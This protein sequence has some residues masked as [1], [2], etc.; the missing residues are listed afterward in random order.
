MHPLTFSLTRY[1]TAGVRA[2]VGRRRRRAVPLV[3]ATGA[4]LGLLVAAAPAALAGGGGVPPVACDSSVPFLSGTGGY[5]TF[6][7]PSAVVL[8]S[9]AL[10]AFAEG[11]VSGAGDTG[12][13][14]V[15]ARRSEDG[16]CS[17]GPL[18]VVAEG[19]GDT[20]G[21]PAPVVDPATGRLVL[22]TCYNS[23]E[24]GEGQIMRGEVTP[25][26][27]RR[28]FVQTSDDEGRTFTAPREIT[29]QAKLPDWRWYATGPGHAIALTTGEHAGRLL[30]PANH[31]TA[32][33]AGSPD[34]GQEARYYGSHALYSDDG[35]VSWE[36]GYIDDS[37]DGLVNSNES[38]VAELPD[39]RLYFSVR[40]Q[41]GEAAGN[42]L[43]GYSSDG[44][45]SLEGPLTAQPGLESVPV[46]QGSVLR[47]PGEEG[48]L[49]FS[50][51]SNPGVREAL[52]VW[53][54]DD[55]GASFEP[56]VTLSEQPAAYSDLVRLDDGTV[57]V[58]YE[59]GVQGPY[60]TV[61]FRRLDES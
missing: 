42:R 47:L 57:G 27:S 53:R 24:V 51:P 43:G 32:P 44:G 39:G 23:G 30:V 37:Y 25:E 33:P 10:L 35:G 59:T 28:V 1:P 22:V 5:D 26:Q 54:S 3:V 6:R 8:P 49:L 38:S 34:T 36:L 14:D 11:R 2:G 55:D 9:G 20:R 56:A 7:V 58:L 40:D 4:V 48:P 45:A 61:E 17:W 46:V 29:D 13:I 18:T 21:N 15:V 52:T 16:G 60:E 50:G 19:A 12:E 41:N 31:S